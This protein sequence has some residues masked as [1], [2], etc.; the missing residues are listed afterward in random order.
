M[1]STKFVFLFTAVIMAVFCGSL[2]GG[3]AQQNASEISEPIVAEPEDQNDIADKLDAFMSAYNEHCSYKYSGTVL[4]A[5]GDEVLLNKGY[6]TA[7][8]TEETKNTSDSVFAIGSIT[9]SITAIA[10]MQLHQKGL[11]NVDDPIS[12]YIDHSRG[13]DITIHHLLTHTAGLTR[14]GK[15]SQ[16]KSISLDK[17]VDF[18]K[19]C[20]MTFEP[21]EDYLYSN[22]GYIMLAGIIEKVTGESY[23]DY[24]INHIF[25]PLEMNSSR[26]GTDCSYADDQSI[27]YEILTGQ[28]RRMTIYNF[29]CITG[30]GNLYSTTKDLY[31]Y[32]RGITNQELIGQESL[33]TIF[34]P[35]W[36]D[37]NY[38]YGYGWETS[39][40]YGHKKVSHGGCIGNGGYNSL[41]IKYPDDDY[42]LIFLTN[43]ADRTALDAVSQSLEAIIFEEE[44]VM[45]EAL[46]TVSVD[47]EVLKQ[48]ARDYEFSEGFTISVQYKDGKLYSTAD[49]AK[50]YE[51]FPIS[52]TSFVYE[53]HQCTRCEF[54]VKDDGGVSIKIQSKTNTITGQ[55]IK[56]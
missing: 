46:K 16:T 50:L 29:S 20:A 34:T 33:D 44:Y 1:K 43:N 10:I 18:I 7:N 28:P 52:E 47:Q 23:N 40:R 42:V 37:W 25:V 55:K 35:Y 31:K 19:K 45:P 51:L 27:G 9:K 30:C 32:D 15:F 24:I 2:V 22:A 54:T 11:L 5:K 8:Y 3:C 6:G 21:G 56:E 26:C 41:M 49:D 17:N 39:Q 36:G 53:D 48:Y 38:G 14:E 4:V 13:D 12:K